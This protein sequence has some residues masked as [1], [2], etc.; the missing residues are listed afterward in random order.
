M[1]NRGWERQNPW[2]GVRRLAV[3]EPGLE[4]TK[5]RH[6]VQ[7]A[8]PPSTVLGGPAPASSTPPHAVCSP[9]G[10]FLRALSPYCP[11]HG[12]Y[13]P[14]GGRTL[15]EKAACRVMIQSCKGVVISA[16]WG[17]GWGAGGAKEPW[18]SDRSELA[19]AAS[20]LDDLEQVYLPC[21]AGGGTVTLSPS[22]GS[23]RD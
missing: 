12:V 20:R 18:A 3:A 15:K 10:V 2:L 6:Q 17:W 8:G 23:W 19:S 11:Q 9:P 7:A 1:R 21:T 13:L 5:F 16:S 4:P 14:A 22:L